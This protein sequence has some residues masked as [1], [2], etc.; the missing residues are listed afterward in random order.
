MVRVRWSYKVC[1]IVAESAA[2]GRIHTEPG[3]RLNIKTVFPGMRIPML[4]TRRSRDRLIFNIGIPILARRHLYIE[5]P[6]LLLHKHVCHTN[7]RHWL[8][9]TQAETASPSNIDRYWDGRRQHHLQTLTDTETVRDS[10][11]SSHWLTLWQSE[12][13]P[14]PATNWHCDS[15][16]QHHPQQL[17]DTETVEDSTTSIYW[18]TLRQLKTVPLPAID[19][20]C[21]NRRWHRLHSRRQCRLHLLAETRR[22]SETTPLSDCLSISQRLE[23]VLSPTV[24]MSMVGGGAVSDCFSVSQ[25]LEAVLTF[26]P[27]LTLRQSETTPA[28]VPD[29]HGDSPT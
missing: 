4:K 1:P 25:W 12:I 14:H 5:T 15:Q 28:P 11:A 6:P 19:W 3:L 29:W 7:M 22:Q 17:T 9:R 16:R 18:L 21:D 20:N 23:V 2:N 24:S 8:T 27:W 26:T 13:A 10:T